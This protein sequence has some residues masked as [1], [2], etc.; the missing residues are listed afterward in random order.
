VGIVSEQKPGAGRTID[1]S[2]SL[3]VYGG[4]HWDAELLDEFA[5]Y[6]KTAQPDLVAHESYP[7]AFAVQQLNRP[8][9]DGVR[10]LSYVME[11][12]SKLALIDVD[13]DSEI[14]PDYSE[15]EL[16]ELLQQAEADVV[17]NADRGTQTVEEARLANNRLQEIDSEFYRKFI[18]NRDIRM[19]RHLAWL[20]PQYDSILA[21]V[22][23][24][25]LESVAGIAQDIITGD[26]AG[27][28]PLEPPVYGPTDLFEFIVAK[29]ELIESAREDLPESQVQLLTERFDSIEQQYTKETKQLY[30]ASNPD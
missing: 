4:H 9:T 15:D 27:F 24:G 26:D 18:V 13:W 6:L 14:Y 11:T 7:L 2:D 10:I 20:E 19:A 22:G 17:E 29:D 30:E 16:R 1:V 23:L 5:Q 25:H 3:T 8:N 12:D 28:E 21:T